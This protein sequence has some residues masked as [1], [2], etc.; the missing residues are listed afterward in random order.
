[1]K[2]AFVG[3]IFFDFHSCCGEISQPQ[4]RWLLQ[5]F[6]IFTLNLGKISILTNIFQRGGSTTNY[7]L[8]D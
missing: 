6:F 1:M 8:K 2:L 4:T 5:I 3:S 7:T